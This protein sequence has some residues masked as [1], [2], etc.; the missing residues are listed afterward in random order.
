MMQHPCISEDCRKVMTLKNPLANAEGAYSICKLGR[1]DGIDSNLLQYSGLKNS[2]DR[3]GWR[4]IVH[5]VAKSQNATVWRSMQR[6]HTVTWKHG[7]PTLRQCRCVLSC[8]W[9][10]DPM[11]CSPPGS[12]FHE[13]SWQ[14][15]WN[16]L[17][18][19][20]PGDLPDTGIKLM[21]LASLALAD[22]FF[23]TST[24]WKATLLVLPFS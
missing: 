7:L 3:G 17:P 6:A 18:F 23:T 13:I 19:P 14:E 4:A 10:C 22:G 12:S 1:S 5:G 11:D 8:I 15:Y 21:P 20:P 24:P 16:G 2:M 9:L